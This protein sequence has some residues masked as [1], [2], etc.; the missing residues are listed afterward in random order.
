MD[1]LHDMKN[2]EET[3]TISY[4]IFINFIIITLTII[5]VGGGRQ[6]GESREGRGKEGRTEGGEKK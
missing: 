6:E 1:N 5:L 2:L 4:I 3:I